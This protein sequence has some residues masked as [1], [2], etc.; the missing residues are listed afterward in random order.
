MFDLALSASSRSSVQLSGSNASLNTILF[1]AAIVIIVAGM[2]VS[3]PILVPVLLALFIATLSAPPLLWLEKKGLPTFL[4]LLVVI[5]L[6]FGIGMLLASLV[7][8]SI[9]DFQ[10][11][12]PVYEQRLEVLFTA[13]H[14][15]LA[16]LG[17]QFQFTDIAN[18]VNPPSVASAVGRVANEIGSLVANAFLIFLMVIFM[19]F[20]VSTLP[21][22]LEKII[23]RPAESMAQLARFKQNL[24][25][26]LVIK[27]LASLATAALVWLMLQILGVDFAILWA[28]LAFFLNF[29]PNIGSIIAAV[30]AVL[31]T[32]LQID[33]TTALWVALGYIA[34]NSIIGSV[35][36]PRVAGRHLG[37]SP[38][39]VFMSLIFWG[40]VLGPVGMFLSVPLTMMVRLVAESSENLKWLAIV[41][42]DRA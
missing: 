9:A 27:S 15:T 3:S 29:V 34:I 36:E 14:S 7:G 32:L 25:R 17:I 16:K 28:L 38:L 10:N 2:K 37:L 42:S 26:Y 6:I 1:L 4:A 18:V 13:T 22:K 39:I 19:L 41:L 40:W 21:A 24:Q 33:A 5:S 23:K 35:I 8:K 20:E 30:P 31:I 12:L 11:Q